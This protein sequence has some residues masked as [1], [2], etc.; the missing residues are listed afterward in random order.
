ML[1]HS[2]PSMLRAPKEATGD[3]LSLSLLAEGTDSSG[4]MVSW[5][6]ACAHHSGV[7]V[8]AELQACVRSLG[9]WFT[10][11]PHSL[12]E[13]VLKESWFCH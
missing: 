9:K 5:L 12:C 13:G 2:V 4:A 7:K 6:L 10:L 8:R 11:G 1:T 3:Q